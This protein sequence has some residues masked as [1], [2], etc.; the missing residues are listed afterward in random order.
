M[1]CHPLH[2]RGSP[3]KG[4]VANQSW[5]R[6][7]QKRFDLSPLVSGIPENARGDKAK[8]A[9]F[10]ARFATFALL[11]WGSPGMQGVTKSALA[12]SIL[13]FG[14]PKVGANADF[15]TFAFSGI[16]NN[17][18]VTKAFPPPFEARFALS[19]FAFSGIPNKAGTNQSGPKGGRKCYITLAFSG[20]PKGKGDKSKRTQF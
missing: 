11:S 18:G 6:G 2:S 9:L 17:A 4:D 12:A 14:G 8:R 7:G 19:P 3:R 10:W 16:P 1:I 5:P 20:I 13:P 15:V